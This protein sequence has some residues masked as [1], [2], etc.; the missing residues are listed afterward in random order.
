MTFGMSSELR[1]CLH[2]HLSM[3]FSR[4]RLHSQQ[5][6]IEH[7]LDAQGK[8]LNPRY[9][10]GPADEGVSPFGRTRTL[11]SKLYRLLFASKAEM[12]H[13]AAALGVMTEQ[14]KGLIRRRS[15]W[16]MDVAI[17]CLSRERIL[18]GRRL[19]RCLRSVSACLGR[20]LPVSSE[21]A[22]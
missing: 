14:R 19:G 12:L 3:C 18:P 5:L 11:S 21:F 22:H 20:H 2:A 15:L 8:S 13:S 6:Y 1:F 7:R 10:D 9:Q 17:L 4:V 16:V